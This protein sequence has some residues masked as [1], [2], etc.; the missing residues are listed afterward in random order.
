MS[1]SWASVLHKDAVLN[2]WA[3]SGEKEPLRH[4]DKA[5]QQ[6]SCI[7]MSCSLCT[8]AKTWLSGGMTDFF[9]YVTIGAR[10]RLAVTNSRQKILKSKHRTPSF[11]MRGI[12]LTLKQRLPAQTMT[13]DTINRTWTCL[14]RADLVDTGM[15][16]MSSP[17]YCNIQR[18]SYFWDAKH[19]KLVLNGTNTTNLSNHFKQFEMS[20]VAWD[21]QPLRGLDS[22]ESTLSNKIVS[23]HG[24]FNHLYW[25]RFCLSRLSFALTRRYIYVC[26][27][28]K[29]MYF[30]EVHCQSLAC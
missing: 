8:S 13:K 5:L 4:T 12:F 18:R 27:T 28:S 23:K 22:K 10:T 16:Q 21:L 6:T 25:T 14:D 3:G 17:C 20:S 24:T 9:Q 15:L 1:I 26:L 29:V 30:S 7:M 2:C 11:A 19:G